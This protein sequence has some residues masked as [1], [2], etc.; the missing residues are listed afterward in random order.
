MEPRQNFDEIASF[1]FEQGDRQVKIS[2]EKWVRSGIVERLLFSETT[3]PPFHQPRCHVPAV[4]YR[5]WTMCAKCSTRLHA[6]RSIFAS[7]F[8]E[9]EPHTQNLYLDRDLIS[10]WGAP[11]CPLCHRTSSEL[12]RPSSRQ[13]DTDQKRPQPPPNRCRKF[14]LKNATHSAVCCWPEK[15]R[16]IRA[17][18]PDASG[19]LH[20]LESVSH[21]NNFIDSLHWGPDK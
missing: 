9:D 6:V 20:R 5:W 2:E 1:L 8:W 3:G 13:V 18:S 12:L 15:I 4:N 17:V 7:P 21:F 11:C 19:S 16:L 14:P 10:V